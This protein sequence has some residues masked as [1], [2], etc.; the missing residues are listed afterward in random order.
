MPYTGPILLTGDMVASVTSA[1]QVSNPGQPG[2]G[3]SLTNVQALGGSTT[4]YR[5]VWAQNI[6]NPGSTDEF[7]NGQVWRLDRYVGTGDPAT[8][9]NPQSWQAV[10]GYTDLSPRHDI[11]SGVGGG[12]EYI[13]FQANNSLM[14]YNINGG[15][16]ATPTNQFYSGTA[17]AQNG[18]PAA[19]DNDS[20]LDFN[21]ASAAYCFCAGAMIETDIGPV[22]VER[23][24]VGDRVLTLDHGLQPIRWIGRR[25]VTLAETVAHPEILPV[26]VAAG[27]MAPGLPLRDLWLSPQHRVL[28]RSKIAE[29]M[30]GAA[31]A[32]VAVKHLSSLPGIAKVW[33]P[34]KV[35]YVHLR[36][37]RHE[38]ILAE[39]IWAETLLLGPQALKAMGPA[40]QHELELLFP[41]LVEGPKD[42]A[43]VLVPGHAGRS[44]AR[45]HEQNRK[46]LVEVGAV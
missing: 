38:V 28:V 36:L 24:A 17:D 14:L 9:A 12:D 7:F 1:N 41:G 5:L 37:D 40:A 19:G 20:Q 42:A 39:G 8:D 18:D 45:R 13:M 22:A 46:V 4:S 32:L 29:R 23:L 10:P 27:V 26:R 16:P 30:T 35:T 3:M 44:L 43:R 21:D 31:E 6:N 2:F 34:R 25:E 33:S 15:L 11:V